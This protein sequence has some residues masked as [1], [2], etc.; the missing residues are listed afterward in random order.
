M[1]VCVCVCSYVNFYTISHTHTSLHHSHYLRTRF[2]RAIERARDKQRGSS[3]DQKQSSEQKKHHP[4][5]ELITNMGVGRMSS[6]LSMVLLGVKMLR[7]TFK[8]HSM[9]RKDILEKLLLRMI[10]KVNGGT[11]AVYLLEGL[12]AQ[13]PHV[14]LKLLST[15]KDTFDYLSYLQVNFCISVHAIITVSDSTHYTSYIIHHTSYIIHHT[16]Y[17]IHHALYITHH[18]LI[19]ISAISRPPLPTLP[20]TPRSTE[21]FLQRLCYTSITKDHVQYR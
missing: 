1:Y 14:F 13:R 9:V 4:D 8:L 6:Q 3:S 10:T 18:T 16:S 21:W 2:Y 5:E 20:T 15:L 7:E 17:I 12:L 19:S 11:P